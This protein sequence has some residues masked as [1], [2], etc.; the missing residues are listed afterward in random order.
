MS[1]INWK[2][3]VGKTT[4]TH[5]LATGIQH[6]KLEKVEK[7]FKVKGFPRILLIDADAQCDLS[8]LCLGEDIF[9]EKIMGQKDGTLNKLIAKV[10][11]SEQPD[12]YVD[13]HII[14]RSVRIDEKNT[15][16]NID[17]ISSHPNLIFTDMDIAEYSRDKLKRSSLV[18][19]EMY[20]F[21]IIDNILWAIK[22]NYD[23]VF[24]DCPPNLYY[25]TQNALY[26]SDY[27]LIPTI[28]DRL[29]CY[30]VPS[31]YKKVNE[32]NEVFKRNYHSY[33]D[34]KLCGV[35]VNKVTEYSK[36]PKKTQAR[37]LTTLK[38]SFDDKVFKYYLNDGDG[39]PM[40]Y[41]HGYS[42]FELK[43]KG[44]SV[45]KQR[46]QII[47]IIEEFASKIYL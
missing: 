18:N 24:I 19:D 38:E 9:E 40:A 41:E 25:I 30:G 14:K 10:L 12:L 21:Q 32:L 43:N 16:N 34:T 6:M 35:V 47:N 11:V 13:K 4:L 23:L 36:E 1:I 3:G 33:V 31:I 27:Y 5:H 28:P 45:K 7:L 20:K 37:A 2:G 29:S 22:D 26:A 46:K 15:Y 42:A 39:I 8:R 17:I 44:S